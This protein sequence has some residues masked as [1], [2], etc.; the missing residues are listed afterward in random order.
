[1]TFAMVLPMRVSA[2]K[3]PQDHQG[4]VHFAPAAQFPYLQRVVPRGG[5]GQLPVSRHGHRICA[6]LPWNRSQQR[7]TVTEDFG[8]PKSL[9]RESRNGPL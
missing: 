5:D 9:W 7:A 6:N 3:C 4:G 2:D 1:M 8:D